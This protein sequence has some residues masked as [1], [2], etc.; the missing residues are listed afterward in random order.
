MEERELLKVLS[1]N[2]KHY[3]T[4]LNWSQAELAEKVDI[5]INFLSDIETGKKWASPHTMVKLAGVFNIEAYELLKPEGILPDG[6]TNVLEKYTE[7][8]YRAISEV[9]KNYLKKL[10]SASASSRHTTRRL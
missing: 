10:K 4:R 1:T 8:V 7:D 6:T 5:S 2:I 3:R 9:R